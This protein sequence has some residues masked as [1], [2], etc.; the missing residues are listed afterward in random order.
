M[1]AIIINKTVYTVKI[2]KNDNGSN[3]NTWAHIFRK[4]EKMPIA[5]TLFHDNTKPK[6]IIDWAKVKIEEST[7]VELQKSFML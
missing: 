6:E 1:I 4:G 2:G 3:C 5:G 7:N